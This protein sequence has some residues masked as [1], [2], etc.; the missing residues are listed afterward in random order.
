LIILRIVVGVSF[1]NGDYG[2]ESEQALRSFGTPPAPSF[3]SGHLSIADAY[4]EKN[5]SV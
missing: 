5:T 2:T 4:D 3:I 1:E